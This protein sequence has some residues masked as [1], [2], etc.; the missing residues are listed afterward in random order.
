MMISVKY[1][2]AY[3]FDEITAI[4]LD[5]AKRK[6]GKNKCKMYTISRVI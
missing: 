4:V 2:F 5:W 3:R 1:I 6:R